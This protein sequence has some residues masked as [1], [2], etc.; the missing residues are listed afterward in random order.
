[1]TRKPELR[2]KPPKLK[3]AWVLLILSIPVSIIIALLPLLGLSQWDQVVMLILLDLLLSLDNLL[4]ILLVI[5]R[6]PDRRQ[7]LFVLIVGLLLALIMRVLLTMVSQVLIHHSWLIILGGVLLLNIAN[8]LWP[9]ETASGQKLERPLGSLMATF[10]IALLDFL[11]SLD[12]AMSNAGIARN[13]MWLGL[14]ALALSMLV[15]LCLLIINTLVGKG[16]V[17]VFER[18]LIRWRGERIQLLHRLPMQLRQP[19]KRRPGYLVAGT[20]HRRSSAMPP[21]IRPLAGRLRLISSEQK[22][23][24][25]GSLRNSR[26]SAG[27]DEWRADGCRALPVT[28]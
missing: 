3:W 13:A 14:G 25:A 27:L 19:Q 9:E 20:G 22:L 12:N 23:R 16:N 26:G 28:E 4:V 7:R 8:R 10:L 6:V 2:G 11:A 18:W 21:R 1:L 15:L 5:E 24:A 17:G